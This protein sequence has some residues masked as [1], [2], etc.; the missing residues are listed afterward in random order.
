MFFSLQGDFV[1]IRTQQRIMGIIMSI[2]III[3]MTIKRYWWYEHGD[4]NHITTTFRINIPVPWCQDAYNR[5]QFHSLFNSLLRLKTTKTTNPTFMVLDE[6]K[7]LMVGGF[8]S[9]WTNNTRKAFLCHGVI[10]AG[11]WAATVVLLTLLNQTN[12]AIGSGDYIDLL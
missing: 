3:I 8:S 9:T 10:H 12:V 7:P 5:R 4:T 11:E 1:T 2:M 6:E